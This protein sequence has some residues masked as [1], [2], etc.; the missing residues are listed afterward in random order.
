MLDTHVH[1]LFNVP[2]ADAFVDDDTEGGLSHVVDDT[3]L[4]MVNFM[5]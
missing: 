2:V 3:G 4:A 1:P 5:G